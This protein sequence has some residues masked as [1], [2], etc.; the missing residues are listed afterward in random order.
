MI[1]SIIVGSNQYQVA[2]SQKIQ[3]KTI[4]IYISKSRIVGIIIC[5]WICLGVAVD[6]LETN[7]WMTII[8]DSQNEHA[9]LQGLGPSCLLKGC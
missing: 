5:F 4:Y 7:S 6:I 3:E 9:F 8:S 1:K 2:L